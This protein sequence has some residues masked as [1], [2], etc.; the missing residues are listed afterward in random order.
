LSCR[1]IRPARCRHGMARNS[2]L[3]RWR[4]LRRIL[5]GKGLQWLS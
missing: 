1:D 2:A 5:S 3:S 4:R